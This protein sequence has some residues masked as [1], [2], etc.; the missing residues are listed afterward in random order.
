MAKKVGLS[1]Y[2][3]SLY[4]SEEEKNINL[5]NVLESKSLLKVINDYIDE[6]GKEYANDQGSE[7]LYK[8]DNIEI[9]DINVKG[10]K[11]YTVLSGII[12]TG[13]YGVQSEL[14]DA[15]DNSTVEKKSTQ[16][17]VLPFGFCIALAEGD[18]NKAVVILRTLGNLGIK[19]VFTAYINKCLS[20]NKINK[21]AVWGPLYPIEYVKRIM[22]RGKLEK[23]RLIRYEVPEETVN[24]LGVNNGVKLR[25]EHIIINPVGFVKN[26]RDKIIEC[27]RGQRASTN[28]IELPE[29]NYDVLKFEFSMNKKKKTIDLNNLS[30]LKIN[31]D[32]TE[33]V[34][35]DGGIPTYNSLKIRMLETAHEYLKLLGFIV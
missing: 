33:Q 35:I 20:K 11:E 34:R 9:K 18:K 7:R 3:M 27:L 16:A 26:K 32:I 22:D 28:I 12:K 31:E 14:V 19:S 29:F 1:I 8:F 21:T 25:E 23:I 24:R 15:I 4:S 5:N 13:E 10:R 2:G 17:E 6:N 30:E